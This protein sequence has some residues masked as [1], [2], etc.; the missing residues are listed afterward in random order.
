MHLS[1]RK[2]DVDNH[3]TIDQQPDTSPLLKVSRGRTVSETL[4]VKEIP[5]G[6][7]YPLSSIGT[8]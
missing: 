1:N 2:S 5:K 6:Q 3:M 4:S 8:S 7:V